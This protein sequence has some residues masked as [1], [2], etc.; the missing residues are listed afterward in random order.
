MR[1]I[2]KIGKREKSYES[3]PVSDQ[4]IKVDLSNMGYDCVDGFF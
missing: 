1:E 3:M 4:N 2:F